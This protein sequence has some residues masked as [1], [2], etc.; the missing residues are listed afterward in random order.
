MKANLFLIFVVSLL[1]TFC[2]L[3]LAQDSDGDGI[4]DQVDIFPDSVTFGFSDVNLG[5][6]TTGGISVLGDQTLTITEVPNP[7][8]VDITAAPSG[9][10]SPAIIRACDNVS[11]FSFGPND[12]AIVTCGS[13]TIEVI[14]GTV[15]VTFVA[16]DGTRATV[17][18]T[19]D[20]SL[21]FEPASGTITAPATNTDDIVIVVEGTEVTLDPGE[22][23]LLGEDEIALVVGIDIKPGSDPNC[24]N[25]GSEGVIPVAILGSATF[26]VTTV[27]QTTLVFEGSAARIKGKSSNIGSFDDVN[28][29]G[30][31]DLVV[32]FPTATL[33]LTTSDIEATLTGALLDGTN[34]EGMDDICIVPAS[35]KIGVNSDEVSLPKEYVLFENHPNPFNPETEIRFQLPEA[36]HVVVRIFNALGQEIRTLVDTPYKAGYHSVR[37]DGKDYNGNAVSS[38]IYFYRLQAGTFSQAKK[39]SLI[40]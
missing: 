4:A 38:G 19:E 24:I 20:N 35:S 7:D 34:I 27:D 6:T 14:V 13:V 8:G 28:A 26:D 32:Q 12:Q 9:G 10:A 2:S 39:M 33:G 40:Q 30:I 29:D 22:Q 25:L 36:N 21:T 11:E 1:L 17:D 37:W 16:D 31:L 15:E 5:G 3:I 18:L 23:V